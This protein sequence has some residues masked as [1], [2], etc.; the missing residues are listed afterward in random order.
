MRPSPMHYFPVSPAFMILLFVALA[1]VVAIVELGVL[2]YAYEKMGIS[3]RT[4]F[5]I[6]LLSLFGSAI[7]IPIAEMPAKDVVVQRTVNF[8][9]VVYAV[10]EV[11]HR[12]HTIIAANLGGAVIPT[13]LSVYLLIKNRIY[14]QAAL[15]VLVMTGITHL[16]ARPVP[17]VGIALP[18]LVPPI[19]AAIVALVISRQHAAPLAYIA[20]SMGCLLGADVLNLNHIWQLGAPIASIGGAGLSDGIF[21]TGIIAV[22]LA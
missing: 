22:L 5:A 3:P 13:V 7:N 17:G 21:L 19:L 1:V 20:G 10:P 18:T 2:T 16:L 6:L 11:E 14:L 15:G 12:G 8:M 4:I 9:G